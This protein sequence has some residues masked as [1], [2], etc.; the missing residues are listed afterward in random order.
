MEKTGL[1]VGLAL[2]ITLITGGAYAQGRQTGTISGTTFDAQG[3]LLP[4][5]TVTVESSALQGTRTARSGV[6]GN[7][8]IPGLPPGDYTITFTL[9]EFADVTATATV[10]LGGVEEVTVRMEPAQITEVVAVVGVVPSPIASTGTDANL[11][12]AETD[13]LPLGRTV[14]RVAELAPGVSKNAPNDGQLSIS[15]SF[16][17]DNVF[18]IDGVDVTENIFGTAHDLFIEDALEETQ[19]LTTGISAE[20][21]RFSGGVINVITKSGSNQF[22]GS[23]RA[24]L[25]KPDWTA[26]TP[27][28]VQNDQPRTGDLADNTSYET[29]IG[30]PVLHDRLWFFYGNRRQRVS[31]DQVFSETAASYERTSKNDRNLIKFTGTIDT[32]HT[33]EGSYLKNSTAQVQ[34]SFGFSIDPA[35]LVDRELPN[36]LWVVTYRGATTRNMF[37]EL[38]VSRKQFG[39]RNSGGTAADIRESPML[40]LTQQFGHFNAPYFDATDPQDRDNQQIT[41]NAT[42]FLDTRSAGTHSLKAGLEHYRS[43]LVGGN[44][45]S[46]T[47]FVFQADYAVDAAGSPLSDASGRLIP[48]F[49]PGTVIQDWRPV[50]GATLDI[51]TLSFYVNDSWRMGRHLSFNLGLRSENVSSEATGGVVGVDTSAVVPRL[52]AAY[53]PVGDG[54]YTFQA[55]YGHYAGRYSEAQFS[56]NTNVGNPDL[57][58]GIYNGPTGQGRDFAP[59]F[60][61]NNYDIVQGLFPAQNVFFDDLSSPLT[62]EFTLSGGAMVADRGHVK[63]TFVHRSMTDFVE[64]F[65]TLDGGSTTVMADGMSFGTFTNRIFR[66]TDALERQYDALVFQSRAQLTNDFYLDGSWTLQINNDGS[67]EGELTQ[68]PAIPSSAFDY[69]EITPAARYFPTGRLDRFQRHKVRIWGIYNLDLDSAGV[70][71]VGGVWRYD[72]GSAYSLAATN[73]G[74]TAEQRSIL[75]EL[76]YASGPAPRTL[77]FDAGRGSETFDGY[78]L[79]DLSFRYSIPVWRSIKPWFEAEIFNV[80]NNDA[81]IS[82]NTSVTPDPNGPVDNLGLPTG[83]VEGPRFGE[84]TSADDYPQYL[85]GLNGLRTIRFSMGFRF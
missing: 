8:D 49:R 31:T 54:R 75:D 36:D 55:T 50:R 72:S 29:T 22:S 66:N 85:P 17:Y 62:K 65:F 59:G 37:T 20:Y 39:L 79:F 4:G 48:V 57:L 52:A 74:T 24:N 10:S 61:P 16:G 80:F 67:F 6:T 84:A 58:L 71:D 40:T 45:Q 25:Y 15:G 70:I 82:W 63:V 28:E 33:L 7:F 73:T 5:V 47:G 30:G 23:F 2:G 34:P 83:L 18:L 9:D 21:G 68:R 35:T 3:L 69:E 64:D 43:T 44:S 1:I 11:T 26:R 42:Y 12:T 38:Q 27:F 81:R 78:G 56:Q 53:D 19:V 76:G 14:F 60:D 32:G 41:G 51:D 77:F 46:S 13:L